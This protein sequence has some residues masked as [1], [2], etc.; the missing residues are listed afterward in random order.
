MKARTEI[1]SYLRSSC[2]LIF[3]V[4]HT[5]FVVEVSLNIKLQVGLFNRNHCDPNLLFY[6]NTMYIDIIAE[7]VQWT[8][9]TIVLDS[10]LQ[11]PTSLIYIRLIFYFILFKLEA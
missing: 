7:G 8:L 6:G 10:S 9:A 11:N 2:Y 1:S 4:T 5:F 3:S